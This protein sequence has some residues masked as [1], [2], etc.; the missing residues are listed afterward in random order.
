MERN[1]LGAGMGTSPWAGG[2]NGLLVGE[3]PTVGA[4]LRG[5]GPRA[6]VG[7]GLWLQ[8]FLVAFLVERNLELGF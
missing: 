4:D 8:V 6:L 7:L 3:L 5:A 1:G 2:G